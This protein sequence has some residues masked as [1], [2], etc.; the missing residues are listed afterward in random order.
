M[1]HTDAIRRARTITCRLLDDPG[2]LALPDDEVVTLGSRMAL[3]QLT[4]GDFR[5]L[6]RAFDASLREIGSGASLDSVRSDMLTALRPVMEFTSGSGFRCAPGD[7]P[8]TRDIGRRLCIEDLR[9]LRN[10]AETLEKL[11]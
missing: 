2:I 6:R 4:A 7:I 3:R 1:M 8:V 10:L 11:Q 9:T 5:G